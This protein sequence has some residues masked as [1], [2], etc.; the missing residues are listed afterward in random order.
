VDDE[1]FPLFVAGTFIFVGLGN[2]LYPQQAIESNKRFMP[3]L[4]FFVFEWLGIERPRTV[5]ISGYIWLSL[6]DKCWYCV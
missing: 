6:P 2:A 4:A 1:M 3:K 5:R